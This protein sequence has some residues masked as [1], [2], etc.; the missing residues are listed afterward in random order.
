MTLLEFVK[1]KR[2]KIKEIA[3]AI[4]IKPIAISRW[5]LGRRQVPAERCPDIEKATNGLVRC[6][7]LRPDVDWSILRTSTK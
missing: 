2:G 4:N 7:D 6:E 5:A 3:Q 1:Q